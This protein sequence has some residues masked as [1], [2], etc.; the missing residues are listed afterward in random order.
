VEVISEPEFRFAFLGA[1]VKGRHS[2]R[3]KYH[4]IDEEIDRPR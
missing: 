1:N 4:E 3:T 2:R